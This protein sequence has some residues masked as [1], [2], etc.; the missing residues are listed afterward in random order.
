MPVRLVECHPYVAE[1]VG[2][3]A[4]MR[5]PILYCVEQVDNPGVELRDV[6]LPADAAFSAAF[7]PDLLGGVTVLSARAEAAAPDESW[8]DRLYRTR[9]DRGEGRRTGAAK[10]TAV[11]YHAWANREPG[12]M[13]V[14]LRSR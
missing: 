12:A 11:P 1:N 13:H 5:G 9:R 2:R 8:E 6:V 7:R 4:I 10:L 3:V 14:W